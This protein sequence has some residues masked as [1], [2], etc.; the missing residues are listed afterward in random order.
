MILHSDGDTREA[1]RSLTSLSR[2]AFSTVLLRSRLAFRSDLNV[3]VASSFSYSLLFLSSLSVPLFYLPS[4]S[5]PVPLGPPFPSYVLNGC[6]VAAHPVSYGGGVEN[7][8]EWE[9]VHRYRRS[10][11]GDFVRWTTNGVAG[12]KEERGCT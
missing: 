10:R 5:P 2:S 11:G 7:F 6:D 9:E 1:T 4:F 8:E 3:H 12:A